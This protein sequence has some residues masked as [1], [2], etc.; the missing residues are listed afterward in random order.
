MVKKIVH[1]FV[2]MMLVASAQNIAAALP[3]Y[4]PETGEVPSLAPMLE[5]VNPAVV[6][7]STFS[8]AQSRYNPLLN[9]PF[10]RRFFNIPEQEFHQHTEPRKKQ[11]SAGSGVIVDA[12]DGI[13]IT[14]YHVI[15]SADEVHVGL[16]DGRS[17]NAEI[18][19]TDPELDIAILEIDADKLT[20]LTIADSSDVRVGDFVVAIGNPFG[21]GQTV[22][23]GV[24]SALGRSGLG[25]EGYEN[26]IQTDA[27]INPGN[28]GGA[29]VNLRGELVGINTAIISPAGGNVGIGFAIPTNMASASMNQIVKYGEV[30]RGQIGVGIQDIT[31][32]LRDAFDLENG[33][34]GVLITNV[35][36]G[37]P[38]EDAGLESGDIVLSVNS[39]KTEST[40]QLRSQIAM[41]PIGENVRLRLL[42][43]D[44]K[45]S[46]DVEIGD[47]YSFS[48]IG[49][50]LHPLL[51]GAQFE[52][53]DEGVVVK[54]LK[55]NSRASYSGLR[56]GDVIVNANKIRVHDVKSFTKVLSRSKN[57]I[58]LRVVRGN[59]ALYLVIR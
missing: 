12:A 46:I 28:S 7:I 13:V 8:K 42:R 54:A 51:E 50:D 35:S 57:S 20:A 30:K 9:D 55:P 41:F 19:G 18:V 59:M 43:N 37:S 27:S 53:N 32:E 4:I 21:L 11:Q 52:N 58:L 33:Q 17:F 15:K 26:F 36:D 24:V 38:A 25:I 6:N 3:T 34:K 16:I 47:R 29:L 56:S 44:K 14:N 31:S 49:N 40:S 2:A 45:I 10:F 5:K 23:T 22:T 1:V 39:K 48:G